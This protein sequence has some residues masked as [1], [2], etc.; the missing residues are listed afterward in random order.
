MTLGSTIRD[1]REAA[2]I[3]VQ[4]LA[5]STS[6]RIGLLTEMENN[7]F[8][9]CG[10]D[11]YARGHLRN[12][13][14]KVGIDPQVFIDL[15]NEEHST[16]HR[17]I[18][19]LLAENN[20]M[21]VPREAKRISW[22]LPAGVSLSVLLVIGI[23]QIVIS[24]QGSELSPSPKPS[25]VV[26]S[27]SALP[28]APADVVASTTPQSGPISLKIAAVRGNSYIDIVVD[29]EHVSKGSMFQGESKSFT[30]M[31]AI[32]IYLSNPAGLDLTLNGKALAPLGG[33]NEEVRRTFR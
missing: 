21:Q 26:A 8:A 7:N 13:A 33:Q 20:V 23:V 32:S 18:Q 10:G 30:G 16:E 5:E 6:I 14:A 28:T 27:E 11:T 2:R 1:A 29:G 22:K 19:D 25:T 9:H 3:S 31:T 12:I 4:S 15:Y 24:N 17:A